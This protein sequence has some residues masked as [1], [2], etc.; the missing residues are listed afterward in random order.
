VKR[1]EEALAPDQQVVDLTIAILRDHGGGL[2]ATDQVLDFGC[3]S[4]RHVYEFRDRGFDAW[5]VDSGRYARPRRAADATLFSVAE[6]EPVYRLPYADATFDLVHST[7]V[8]EHVLDYEA[9]F[10]EISRVLKPTG[11]S[12][13]V[14]PARWRPIEPHMY[15]PFGARIHHRGWFLLWA[16]LGI[17]N[18]F[19][20][21]KPARVVAD[22]NWAYSQNG[23]N[24]PTKRQVVAVA[25]R[26][27]SSVQF[28]EASYIR[29]APGRT[30]H[31]RPLLSLAPALASIY[32]AWHTRVL[33]LRK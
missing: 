29:H 10:R 33:L 23:I 11:W 30:R 9:A 3:G 6:S 26:F 25:K 19:Q 17:R 22:L 28:A 4:G 8:F 7:S 13:H 16:T 31:L 27:F 21:G 5:G 12:L 18:E 20:H 14:F 2:K 24:Y 1:H 32:R 15:V